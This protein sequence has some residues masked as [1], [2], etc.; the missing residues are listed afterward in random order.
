MEKNRIKLYVADPSSSFIDQIEGLFF[1]RRDFGI[2]VIE[3]AS[4]LSD[5]E[6]NMSILP[7]VDVFLI[8]AN[9]PDGTGIKMVETL[10][11]NSITQDKPIIFT[12]DTQTRNS[13]NLVDGKGVDHIYQKP[14]N[15][16]EMILK[17]QEL[18]TKK[19]EVIEDEV[20]IPSFDKVV[21]SETEDLTDNASIDNLLDEVNER[22]SKDA[23]PLKAVLGESYVDE[24][25]SDHNN[26]AL[27]KIETNPLLSL[28]KN[29][30]AR[31]MDDAFNATR[32]K[33]IA[34]TSV[35]SSGKTA[36][37]INTAYAIKK[38]AKNKPSICIVD[39]NLLF[40]GVQ[41]Y[42][43]HSE[44]K[45]PP[46]DIYD[47]S[48]DL[49]YLNEDLIKS[50]LVYHEESDIYIMNTPFEPEY[51]HKIGSIR[52]EHI[53]K[54]LVHL[55]DLFDVILIDTPQTITEDMVLFP[56]Q[57][58]DQNIVVLEPNFLNV[59]GTNKFFYV[60]QQLEDNLKE[61]I[62]NKT[63]IVLNKETKDKSIYSE[64]TKDYLSNK[65]FIAHIPESK[66]FTE[67]GS[68]GKFVC[69]TESLAA[70]AVYNLAASIYPLKAE[71]KTTK[72]STGILGGLFK[73]K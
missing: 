58:A 23:E 62:L 30:Q 16:K 26:D 24:G 27:Q 56:V 37:L 2:D 73:K 33:V 46:R 3:T 32:K 22:N 12:V 59:I 10:K 64:T 5:F 31:E 4:K 20:D 49:N 21:E 19:S 40:P 25:E 68:K 18:G 57:F 45:Q 34:F 47:I 69:D 29:I 70:N 53:E 55:R 38:Y 13:I 44:M 1:D 41:Y 72:K 6:E 65:K 48:E 52:S 36:L 63:F 60:L 51:I 35:S 50:T 15:I 71:S 67:F 42:F 14:F 54:I 43:L 28:E 11:S 66:E 7:K 17:I 61:D 8:A 39:L 9:Y